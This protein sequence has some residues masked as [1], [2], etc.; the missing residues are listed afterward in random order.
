[1]AEIGPVSLDS[2]KSD[3]D[4]LEKLREEAQYE[5]ERGNAFVKE[6]KWDEAI[7]CYNRAIELIKDDAIYY[8]NRGLCYLKKDSLHQ[9]VADCTAALNID[10][11]YVKALQRRATARER[12]GSLRAASADLNQVL[13]LEPRNAAAKK[14]LEAIKIRM[15]TK[16]SKSKSSPIAERNNDPKSPKIEELDNT[17]G[18]NRFPS[19]HMLEKWRSGEWEGYSVLKPVKKPPHLR[20]KRALKTISIEEIPFG[21]EWKPANRM[22]IIEIDNHDHGDSN[23][24]DSNK[25]KDEI[26][27]KKGDGDMK[28]TPEYQVKD[29]GNGDS[30]KES[31]NINDSNGNPDPNVTSE[32]LK[33]IID[34]VTTEKEICIKDLVP[35]MN[36]VQFMSEWKNLKGQ[37]AARN[38]YLS[39]IEPSKIPSIFANALE[40]DVLSEILQILSQ[41][42]DMFSNKT[43]TAYLKG[44]V[45]VK[46]FSAL[47]MFLSTAD[48]Q[49]LNK[50]LE[51]CK[52]VEKCAEEDILDLKNKFEL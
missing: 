45:K 23:N 26:K 47:A 18:M 13:T 24:N 2:K 36:S 6:E 27:V 30:L 51:H 39:I 34:E 50:L 12:L 48:K 41:D 46:R 35:P 44:L 20:S 31:F 15:G 1:M 25:T 52:N 33:L 9:A 32:S 22:K 43:V 4:K 17:S 28:I 19:K 42:M 21:V 10:P 40:S 38:K 49:C 16:G 11:S 7:K 37:N 14:Q 3:K 8:A 29:E 5:K